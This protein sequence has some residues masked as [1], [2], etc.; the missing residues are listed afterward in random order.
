MPEGER[1]PLQIIDVLRPIRTG[2][3]QLEIR[4]WEG[5]RLRVSLSQVATDTETES[6]IWSGEM[7]LSV[8]TMV[9]PAPPEN[10]A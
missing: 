5:E 8:G 10:T 3:V 7:R 4:L 1:S 6:T 9:S 2:H